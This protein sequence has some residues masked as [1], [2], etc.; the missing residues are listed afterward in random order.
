MTGCQHFRGPRS[1]T[2]LVILKVAN[3]PY[4]KSTNIPPANGEADTWATVPDQ[5]LPERLVRSASGDRRR[6]QSGRYLKATPI[7]W[8][9]KVAASTSSSREMLLALVIRHAFDLRGNEVK[10]DASILSLAELDG[11]ARRTQRH[12][13]LHRLESAGLIELG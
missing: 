1:S 7:D 8:L 10:L 5:E 2:S 12:R 6:R 9:R 3:D 4:Q 13:A 11:R